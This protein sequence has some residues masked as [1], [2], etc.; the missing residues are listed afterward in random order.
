MKIFFHPIN[1]LQIPVS[2]ENTAYGST[3]ANSLKNISPPEGSIANAEEARISQSNIFPLP[4]S[5]AA[6]KGGRS[7]S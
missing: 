5:K 3:S 2:I 4:K 6:I 7:A 1:D